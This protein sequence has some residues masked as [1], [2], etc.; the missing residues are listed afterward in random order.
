MCALHLMGIQ[1][2]LVEA[3]GRERSKAH[4]YR[5][6]RHNNRNEDRKILCGLKC[7]TFFVF[8]TPTCGHVASEQGQSAGNKSKGAEVFQT[9]WVP[10]V[11][12]RGCRLRV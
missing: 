8:S 6:V 4:M 2:Y 9:Q 10:G 12:G 1:V 7:K 5:F 3:A 11:F